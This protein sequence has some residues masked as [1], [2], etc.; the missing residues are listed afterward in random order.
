VLGALRDHTGS[1]TLSLT[2]L[3]ALQLPQLLAGLGAGRNLLV[4]APPR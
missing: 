3:V 4:S 1:W 2:L